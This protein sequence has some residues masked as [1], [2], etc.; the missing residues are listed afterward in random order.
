MTYQLCIAQLFQLVISI[1]I[2]HTKDDSIR[3]HGMYATDISIHILHTKDDFII[4][5]RR[6]IAD[7]F[8]PHPSHE[9]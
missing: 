3:R 1:H 8:N 2:L 6:V 9:G 5:I 7:Y 4:D